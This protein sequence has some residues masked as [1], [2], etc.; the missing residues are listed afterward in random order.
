MASANQIKALLKSHIEG[1]ERRFYSIA[2]QVAATS[3]RKGHSNVAKEIRNLID[4]GK[5]K[6]NRGARRHNGHSNQTDTEEH[7]SDDLFETRRSD[8][9]LRHMVL[10]P[11]LEEK[12]KWILREQYNLS[13]IK[14]HDLTPRRKLL[15]VGPPGCGKTMSA[16]CIAGELGLPLYVI[17]LD[18]VISKYMG[19]S[20][21]KIRSVFDSLSLTRGVYLFDEFDAIGSDRARSDDVGEIRR[22]LSTFLMM[23]E[24][25]DSDSLILAAT[26]YPE[27]L[28]KALYRRFDDIIEFRLPG[29]KEIVEL[30]RRRVRTIDESARLDWGYIADFAEGLSFAEV[31]GA[32]NEALKEQLLDNRNHLRA[33]DLVEPIKRRLSFKQRNSK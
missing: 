9:R 13:K 24:R 2:M 7:L 21:S 26:N 23:I 11:H 33:E 30:L 18:G 1:D 15:F 10:S 25:D 29:K 31:E 14:S 19:E 32:C 20:V 5:S 4:E 27:G 17:R 22:V 12:L 3:A 28:D 6:K 16:E 8:T